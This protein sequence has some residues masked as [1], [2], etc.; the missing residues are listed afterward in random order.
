MN[1]NILVFITFLLGMSCENKND[2]SSLKSNPQK[3][4]FVPNK[5]TAVKI[6][7]VVW[8]PI[9]GEDIYDEQPF[10]ATLLG[11]SV[12]V[13]TG[14]LQ[15]GSDGGTVLAKIRKM[16]CKIIEITHEK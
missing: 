9:Y 5:E 15:E 4:G 3:D 6:A 12:W 10:E 1:K 13:V 8:L 11:D 14:T 7:E 2:F 16:D